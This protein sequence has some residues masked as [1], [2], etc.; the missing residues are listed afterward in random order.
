MLVNVCYC[1]PKVFILPNSLASTLLQCRVSSIL[2]YSYAKH[3]DPSED[4]AQQILQVP[5]SF[6]RKRP[7]DGCRES[8][9]KQMGTLHFF[10]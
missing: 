7:W 8:C 2:V 5:C 10:Y 9:D 6:I 1:K 4:D 3:K